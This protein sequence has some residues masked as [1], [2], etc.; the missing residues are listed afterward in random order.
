MKERIEVYDGT[1]DRF[2]WVEV[3]HLPV[4]P[5][6]GKA[7]TNGQ[8][9]HNGGGLTSGP[10]MVNGLAYTSQTPEMDVERRPEGFHLYSEEVS[11][12]P[13]EHM[14]RGFVKRMD[15][16]NGFSIENEKPKWEPP[17][18]HWW[19]SRQRKASKDRIS[20]LA[21]APLPGLDVE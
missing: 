12:R 14:P 5:K 20:E 18:K 8:A 13:E 2:V 9:H 17:K 1:S 3:K 16:I 21:E 11:R 6:N 10:G 15:L 19:S 4:S 7:L